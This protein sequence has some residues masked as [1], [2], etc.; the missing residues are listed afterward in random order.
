MVHLVAFLRGLAN[1]NL[2]G[3]SHKAIGNSALES[4][5]WVFKGSPEFVLHLAI[6]Y[7]EFTKVLVKLILCWVLNIGV[8][9]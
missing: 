3:I 9:R 7:I 6:I 4:R 1:V 8:E 2:F 5:V